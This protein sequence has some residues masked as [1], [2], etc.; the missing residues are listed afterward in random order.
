MGSYNIGQTILVDRLPKPGETLL[1]SGYCEGMGGKGSNQAV[2]ARRLGGD[3]LFMGCVGRDRYGDEA[4]K[5]W[6]AEGVATRVGRVP[7]HTGVA[8]IVV[9]REGTNTIVV[10]AGANMAF[11]TADLDASDAIKGSRLVLTQ[12]EIP[13]ETA[14]A[15]GRLG[16][17]FGATTILNPAP[18]RRMDELDLSVFDIVTPNEEEFATVTGTDDLGKGTAALL[19]AG[20]KAA[21]VTL[22]EKGAY[23]ATRDERRH[24]AAPKVNAVD[25]TGAGDAF[26]GAL[27]VAICEG[28]GLED[29]VRFANCAGALTVTK[30]DVIPALPM[31]SD[32]ERLMKDHVLARSSV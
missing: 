10:D 7:A 6:K 3:V 26:N 23:L 9:G 27:A 4:L 31:R 5:L 15:A 22:G 13:A 28:L 8:L 16:R 19:K 32:V 2:A 11:D 30:R 14:V 12:L 17:K 18:A 21:I 24:I 1:G 25:P 29:A 20:A